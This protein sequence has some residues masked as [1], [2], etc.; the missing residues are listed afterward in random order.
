MS[1]CYIEQVEPVWRECF[2]VLRHGGALL[3]GLDTGINFAVDFQDESRLV[4]RLPFN[5]LKDPSLMA[6]LAADGGGV[7][8]SHTLEEQIGGQLRAGF[9]L[10]DLYEDTNGSGVLH[11]LNVPS[12]VATRAVKP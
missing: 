6:A 1:N 12:F 7:Q 9:A 4:H 5:P 10:A 2:R 8:F 11:E 3:A